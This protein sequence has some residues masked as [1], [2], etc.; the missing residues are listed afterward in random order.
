MVAVRKWADTKKEN[1]TCT[2]PCGRDRRE[3][4]AD[5]VAPPPGNRLYFLIRW[6]S[7]VPAQYRF[8][9]CIFLQ[10]VVFYVYKK[11]GRTYAGQHIKIQKRGV[12]LHYEGLRQRQGRQYFRHRPEARDTEGSAAGTRAHPGRRHGLG[13]GTGPDRDAEIQEGAGEQGSS[14]HLP[15]RPQA[16]PGQTGLLPGRLSVPPVRLLPAAAEEYLP[17]NEGQARVSLRPERDPV[18]PGMCPGAGA[19]RQP[20]LLPGRVGISGKAGL[21]HEGHLPRPG[22]AGRGMRL[23]PVGGISEQPF[24]GAEKRQ[25]HLLRLHEFLL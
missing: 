14:R 20:V 16:G 25:C 19:G 6:C 11:R 2:G 9:Y 4:I 24:P 5:E 10:C 8:I 21:R 13:E 3:Q 12:V 22:R 1:R 17:E 18:R 7:D 15:F 23:Y